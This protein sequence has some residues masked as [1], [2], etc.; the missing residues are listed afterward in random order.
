MVNQKMGDP[1]FHYFGIKIAEK[2][3]VFPLCC[4]FLA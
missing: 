4:I 2:A 3:V 1:G